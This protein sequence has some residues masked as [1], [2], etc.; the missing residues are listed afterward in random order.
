MALSKAEEQAIIK[1]VLSGDANAFEKLLLDNQ[2][3]VYNLALK[4]TGSESDALDMSQEAFLKAYSNLKNYRGESRFSV[5][6]YR[7]T[8][9]VCIDFIRKRKR[10]AAISLT[11]AEDEESAEIEIPDEAHTPESEFERREL[12][13]DTR[14]AMNELSAEHREILTMRAVSNMSYEEIAYTLGITEGTVKS[15]IS[16]ARAALTKILIKKGTFSPSDR[17]DSSRKEGV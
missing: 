11:Y 13:N 12:I 15:R 4:M 14:E 3:N 1:E 16:R 7:L 10:T 8:Y 6:L 2:R 5:W 17:Q 9:N